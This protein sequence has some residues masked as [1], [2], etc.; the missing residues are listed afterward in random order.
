MSEINF[1]YFRG[2]P[3][4]NLRV[5]DGGAIVINFPPIRQVTATTV[6][7]TLVSVEPMSAPTGLIIWADFGIKFSKDYINTFKYG[8]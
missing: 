4:F 8:K 2:I 7:Q 5:N 6:S 1:K 3:Q